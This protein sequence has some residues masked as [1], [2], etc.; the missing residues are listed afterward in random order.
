LAASQ[1]RIVLTRDRDLLKRSAITHGC[2]LRAL[3]SELQLREVFDRLDLARSAKPFTRCLSCNTPLRAIDKAQIAARLPPGV[4]Q[5]YERFPRLRWLRARVLGRHA[6]A[7]HAA[8]RLL[9][10]WTNLVAV[11]ARLASETL[12]TVEIRLDQERAVPRIPQ[13]RG[14]VTKRSK[15]RRCMWKPA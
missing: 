15:R 5:R 10:G 11:V 7:A 6:L 1:G 12:V 9:R 8:E 14:S 2:Y 3:R 4:R 13:V